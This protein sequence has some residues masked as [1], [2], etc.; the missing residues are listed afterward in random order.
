M[1]RVLVVAC[2]VAFASARSV[3]ADPVVDFEAIPM[4]G[5]VCVAPCAVYFDAVGDGAR[6]Y[7]PAFSRPFHSLH[8]A[9][10]FG[11]P[12][13]GTWPVSGRS[14]NQAFGAIAGHLYEQPVATTWCCA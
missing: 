4:Q 7:D 13:S 8:F 10:S 14:R 3:L 1:F 12:Q 2:C 5:D 11:D 9:W 6:T